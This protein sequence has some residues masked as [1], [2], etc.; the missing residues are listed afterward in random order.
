MPFPFTKQPDSMD[1]GPACLRMVSEY[2]GKRYTLERLRYAVRAANIA[3]YI[4]RR[5]AAGLQHENRTEIYHFL[6]VGD[7]EGETFIKNIR[8]MLF[9]GDYFIYLCEDINKGEER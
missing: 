2:F 8:D 1:C 7:G 3:E 5:P 9:F 6:V 4:Y